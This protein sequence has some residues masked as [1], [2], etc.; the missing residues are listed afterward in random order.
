MKKSNRT[1]P[2]SLSDI[3]STFDEGV[4]SKSIDSFIARIEDSIPDSPINGVI[5]FSIPGFDNKGL[6]ELL[7]QPK[8]DRKSV[9]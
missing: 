5:S 9:V 6:N 7:A 4:N 1:L 3:F 2:T 8:E